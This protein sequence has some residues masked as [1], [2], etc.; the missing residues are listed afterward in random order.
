M[1]WYKPVN[2]PHTAPLAA[3]IMEPRPTAP[4]MAPPTA[5]AAAPAP[6]PTAVPVAT[7]PAFP[8]PSSAPA[9]SANCRHASI[10]CAAISFP[11]DCI[12]ALGYRIGCAVEQAA[13]NSNPPITHTTLRI[14]ASQNLS[15][16][17][18]SNEPSPVAQ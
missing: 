12:C 17:R 4:E 1:A 15:D 13:S 18:D 7:R 9:D 6:A 3:P 14:M 2:N 11:T 16:F 8:L 10:S 5:P